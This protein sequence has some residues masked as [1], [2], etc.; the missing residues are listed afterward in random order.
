MSIGKMILRRDLNVFG[1]ISLKKRRPKRG[2]SGRRANSINCNKKGLI[3]RKENS[4]NDKGG[5]VL[6]QSVYC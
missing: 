5:E 6:E 2:H 4:S 3:R 1:L